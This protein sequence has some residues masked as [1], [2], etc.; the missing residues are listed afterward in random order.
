MN[1]VKKVKVGPFV[2]TIQ[3]KKEVKT[4]KDEKCYG[5]CDSSNQIIEVDNTVPPDMQCVTLIHELLE[6]LNN[7]YTLNLKHDAI[8]TLDVLLFQIIKDNRN[9]FND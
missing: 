6:A 4:D 5:L 9:L 1:L 3:Y 7:H 8:D 2:Y